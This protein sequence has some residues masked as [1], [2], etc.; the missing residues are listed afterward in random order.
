MLDG[1][2][3]GEAEVNDFRHILTDQDDVGWFDVA[4]NDIAGVRLGQAA[5]DLLGDVYYLVDGK[6][7]APNSLREGFTL[8]IR[9]YNEEPTKLVFLRP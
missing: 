4:V 3:A 6:G 1:D 9:H 2:D 5:S 8:V 7:A